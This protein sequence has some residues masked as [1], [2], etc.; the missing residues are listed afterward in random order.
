MFYSILTSFHHGRG[1]QHEL[2]KKEFPHSL[3]WVSAWGR[4]GGTSYDGLYGKAPP[5]RGI[6]FS[7]QVYERVG[8]SLIEVYKNV[9]KS[10][11]GVV[12]GPR[13]ANR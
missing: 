11:I 4:E 10:V 12:K 13:R 2:L 7:V 1:K 8:I 5:E 3:S 6:F 9:G